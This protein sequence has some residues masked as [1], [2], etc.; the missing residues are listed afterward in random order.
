[1]SAS[2]T[3]D[4]AG[5]QQRNFALFSAL[6]G[7]ENIIF[8]LLIF[9][10]STA[11]VALFLTDFNNLE[12][13]SPLA[14]ALWY[15]GYIAVLALMIRC[16]PQMIRIVSFNPLLIICVLICGLSFLWSLNPD[17]TLR[18][19]VAVMITTIFGLVLAARYDWNGMVQRLAFAF[20]F[21]A[22]MS[23]IIPIALP[24]YGAVSYTHLTLPT[25]YSV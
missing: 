25:I 5:L 3:F 6:R 22:I 8:F 14:R 12:Y 18:R 10:F 9:Q 21:L 1:M 13:E 16:L 2:N 20:G 24:Y 19:S 17:V 23:L 11:L 15:P 4:Q 7:L